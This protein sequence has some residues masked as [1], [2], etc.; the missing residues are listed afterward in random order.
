MQ[1]VA[2]YGRL[3]ARVIVSGLNNDFAQL[4]F[5]SSAVECTDSPNTS[6][7][8]LVTASSGLGK[9][10]SNTRRKWSF[11]DDAC[12]IASHKLSDVIGIQHKYLILYYI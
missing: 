6:P 2:V 8:R 7:L 9:N 12:F 1:S 4:S 10:N 3:L 11:G 5:K